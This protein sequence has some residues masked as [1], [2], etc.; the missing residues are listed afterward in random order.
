MRSQGGRRGLR[1]RVARQG[2][3]EAHAG[4][5]GR[6]RRH[7][8]GA[9]AWRGGRQRKHLV[10]GR[11][12]EFEQPRQPRRALGQQHLGARAQALRE[13][14]VALSRLLREHPPRQRHRAHVAAVF[15]L[16]DQFPLTAIGRVRNTCINLIEHLL[17]RLGHAQRV[18]PG[19][20]HESVRHCIHPALHEAQDAGLHLLLGGF[21][22][23]GFRHDQL[24]QLCAVQRHI[25][26]LGAIGQR[27]HRRRGHRG[28]NQRHHRKPRFLGDAEQEGKLLRCAG[29]RHQ[30]G[31]R[32]V[33]GQ[34]RRGLQPLE[35]P[36]D[37]VRLIG[38][39]G[40]TG[41]H[42]VRIHAAQ[43]LAFGVAWMQARHGQRGGAEHHLAPSQ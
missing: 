9:I 41:R 43:V 5:R 20:R 40:G 28:V 19:L 35:V 3:D 22:H 24:R 13:A 21:P 12:E 7:A 33:V 27:R 38:D 1:R 36:I 30:R 16:H 17:F 11:A 29:A 18:E 2:R 8:A 10:A 39:A 42:R 31:H 15:S 37:Q 6:P 4:R 32:F 14:L 34:A 26:H 25:H 23:H